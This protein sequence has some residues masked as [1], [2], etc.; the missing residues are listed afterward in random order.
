VRDTAWLLIALFVLIGIVCND[1]T[2]KIH[3]T[4]ATY[5][6]DTC[7][8]IARPP[9]AWHGRWWPTAWPHVSAWVRATLLPVARRASGNAHWRRRHHRGHFERRMER[10]CGTA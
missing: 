10:L 3:L 6:R 4:G 1:N 5:P 7:A 9:S 8:C 2:S